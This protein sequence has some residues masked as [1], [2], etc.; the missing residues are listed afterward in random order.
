MQSSR[1]AASAIEWIRPNRGV[2]DGKKIQQTIVSCTSEVSP[3][4]VDVSDAEGCGSRL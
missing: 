4:G 3:H 2:T 1:T